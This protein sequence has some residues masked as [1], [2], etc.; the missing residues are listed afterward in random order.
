M[1]QLKPS[2]YDLGFNN[3]RK[4]TVNNSDNTKM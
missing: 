2:D 4:Q 1:V 3:K